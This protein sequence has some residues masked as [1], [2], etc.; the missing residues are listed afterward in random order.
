MQRFVV[1]S[2]GLLA[3]QPKAA[4]SAEVLS[5]ILTVILPDVP[6]DTRSIRDTYLIITS[7]YFPLSMM[8]PELLIN[9]VMFCF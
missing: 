6:G 5:N 7:C 3:V 8:P 9:L 4:P 2:I 1:L